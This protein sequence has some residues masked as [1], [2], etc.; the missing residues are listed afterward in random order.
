M[1]ASKTSARSALFDPARH[2]PLTTTA[3]NADAAWQAVRRIAAAAEA[4]FDAADAGWKTHPLDDAQQPGA[5]HHLYFGAAGVI[6]ALRHLQ[7]QQAI[8]LQTDFSAAIE[9]LPRRTRDALAHEQHGSASYLLGES[10]ALLLQWRATHQAATADALFDVV[11]GNLRNPAREALWGSPGTLV[12]AIH[13]AEASGEARWAELLQQGMQVLLD[14]MLI[15][16]DTGTWIWEQDLYGAKRRLLGAGHG[17]VGNVYPAFRAAHLLDPALVAVLQHRALETLQA[18]ALHDGD[19]LN[20]H[21][22]VDAERVA[23]GHL[24]LVHDCHGAPGVV[25]RLANA[26]RSADWD[27]LL[28]GAGELVWRAGPLSTKGASLCHGTPG[29]ALACLKLW[30]R[31]DDP[32]WLARGRALAMHSIELVEQ[33]RALHGAGRHSLWTGDLGVACLLWNCITEDDQFPTLDIF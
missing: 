5:Q 33:H 3:W 21:P 23:P 14:E 1:G 18:T 24:P 20:W 15:D 31:F 2:Q 17:F 22:M 8:E 32:I 9:Q 25:C 13:M 6:W 12:A 26:P 10:G 4:E 27:A 30:R 11:R 29:S 16:P 7:H 28:R 19:C